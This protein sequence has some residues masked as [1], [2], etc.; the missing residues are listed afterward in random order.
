MEIQHEENAERETNAERAGTKTDTEIEQILLSWARTYKDA[1][2]FIASGEFVKIG[3]SRNLRRRLY[4]IRVATPERARLIGVMP[5]G[6][7]E[8][9][10]VHWRLRAHRHRAEWYRMHEDITQLIHRK[11]CGESHYIE[12]LRNLRPSATF[13]HESG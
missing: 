2:Y 4:T 7:R 13:I 10:D 6:P 8:E 1:I 3:T 12:W 9:K 11:G 5:G